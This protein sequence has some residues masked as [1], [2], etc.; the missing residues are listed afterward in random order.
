MSKAR[1]LEEINKQNY[2]LEGIAQSTGINQIRVVQIIG[3]LVLQGKI[4]GEI[5]Q[6]QTMFVPGYISSEYL[7]KIRIGISARIL[8][9][10][11][12]LV[13][14]ILPIVFVITVSMGDSFLIE[15]WKINLFAILATIVFVICISSIICGFL[16]RETI[17]GKVSMAFSIVA[18]VFTL[19][20]TIVVVLFLTVFQEFFGGLF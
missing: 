12:F 6:E 9:P 5:N 18:L 15:K 13:A 16:V 11:S 8:T 2:T 14:T 4:K 3:R 7:G 17:S 1:V 19:M 10:I 20:V